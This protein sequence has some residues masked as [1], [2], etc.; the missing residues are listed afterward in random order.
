[1][2]GIICG[3]LKVLLGILWRADVK[4]SLGDEIRIRHVWN[5]KQEC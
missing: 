4:P 3:I 5:K 2:K 1:V